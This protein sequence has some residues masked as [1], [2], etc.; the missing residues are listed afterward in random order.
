MANAARKTEGILRYDVLRNPE[1]HKIYSCYI[2]MKDM[3][4]VTE[5]IAHEEHVKFDT[6]KDTGAFTLEA[7]MMHGFNHQDG[8][9]E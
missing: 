5:W 1:D 9:Q 2:V 8:S 6:F 3:K 4:I 7:K